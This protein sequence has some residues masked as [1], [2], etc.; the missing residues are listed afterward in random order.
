MTRDP[1]Q[2]VMRALQP[3]HS[4]TQALLEGVCIGRARNLS[5]EEAQHLLHDMLEDIDAVAVAM[6]MYRWAPTET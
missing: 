3:W 4:A 6:S 2:R 1:H 5:R